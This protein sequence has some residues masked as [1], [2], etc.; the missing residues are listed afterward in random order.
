M[1]VFVP[2]VAVALL[3]ASSVNAEEAK[4]RPTDVYG[5]VSY[6]L[7]IAS[8]GGARTG[9]LDVWLRE[10]TVAGSVAEPVQELTQ[11]AEA[12][13]TASSMK[14][15]DIAGRWIV[16][17]VRTPKGGDGNLDSSLRRASTD[18]HRIRKSIDKAQRY[19]Y[20]A[21]GE[22]LDGI[23]TDLAAELRLRAEWGAVVETT[24]QAMGLI[25][26]SNPDKFGASFNAFL[27]TRIACEQARRNQQ[28]LAAQSVAP[29]VPSDARTRAALDAISTSRW[30][31]PEQ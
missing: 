27:W 2:A 1:L 26:R 22:S 18:L 23:P 13:C 31:R 4:F 20:L 3:A 28:F 25:W 9:I 11:I 5:E 30:V 12:Y 19:A 14:Y 10:R 21:P 6:L 24:R 16:Q 29:E 7:R 17:N 8:E 15:W